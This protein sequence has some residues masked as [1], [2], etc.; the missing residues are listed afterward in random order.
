MGD[1]YTPFALLLARYS[2]RDTTYPNENIR[3]VI[4]EHRCIKSQLTAIP[5]PA[6]AA[7]VMI[8]LPSRAPVL[9]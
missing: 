5:H 9:R 7:P 4:I 3:D 8:N 6:L 2:H 1:L